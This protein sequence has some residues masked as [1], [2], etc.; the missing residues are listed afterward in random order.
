MEVTMRLLSTFSL[1]IMLIL[2]TFGAAEAITFQP[3]DGAGN[4]SDLWDLDHGKYYTWGIEWD[5]PAGQIIKS[6]S[7]L[8]DDIRN[9]RSPEQRRGENDLW[10]HLFD[11]VPVGTHQHNDPEGGQVDFF[12]GQGVLLNHWHNLPNT[13]QD[14]TYNFSA[15]EIAELNSFAAD[16]AFGFGFDPDCH[17][18]NNGISLT[19]ETAQAPEPATMLL[20]SSGLLGLAGF[21]RKFKKK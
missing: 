9:W 10:V 8:F 18:W 12:D 2:G 15:A 19:I 5:I 16:G 6:A 20:F 1:A 11:T 17:F 13:A 4:T 14:I 21:R 3:N 7:L